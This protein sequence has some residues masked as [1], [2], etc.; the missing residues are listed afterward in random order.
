M[1]H[2]SQTSHAKLIGKIIFASLL[3]KAL[4]KYKSIINEVEKS[5]YFKKLK[6]K[7]SRF[8]KAQ[9]CCRKDLI[10][11]N[12]IAQIVK[13]KNNFEIKYSYEGFN[14]LY[15]FSCVS[16]VNLRNK[17][18]IN[19]IEKETLRVF[20]RLKRI[21]S[22]NKLTHGVIR[23]IIKHQKTF[24]KTGNPMD[25]TPLSQ[26]EFAKDTVYSCWISRLI[27]KLAFLTPQGETKPLKFFFASQKQI[28]KYLIKDLLDKES[29]D[30]TSG[31]IKKP[32]LDEEIRNIL[33]KITS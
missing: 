16:F 4:K 21:N 6:I 12:V 14:T 1:K 25:L 26:K 29:K 18:N 15:V 33:K 5:P 2:K 31:K 24:F 30:L 28:N 9:M 17:G 22:R 23:G 13:K 8:S 10:L 7:V 20:Y 19:K 27:S 11:S 32:Y 3:K